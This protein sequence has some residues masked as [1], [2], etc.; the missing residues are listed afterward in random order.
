MVERKCIYGNNHQWWN[1][2]V[3]V[4]TIMKDGIYQS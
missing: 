2:N 3:S 1:I 4:E